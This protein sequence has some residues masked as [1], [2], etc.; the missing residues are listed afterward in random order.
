MEAITVDELIEKLKKFEDES[1]ITRLEG[2]IEEEIDMELNEVNKQED[3]IELIYNKNKRKIFGNSLKIN[4]HQI[5]NIESDEDTEFYIYLDTEQKIII[6][7]DIDVYYNYSVFRIT[8][9][10]KNRRSSESS[11]YNIINI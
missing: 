7:T 1:I 3:F 5:K 9:N 6:F 2:S 11:Y 8:N 4:F 10:I